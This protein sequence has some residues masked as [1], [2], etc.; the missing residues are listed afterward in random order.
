MWAHVS[1]FCVAKRGSAP[2]E[3]ED[4]AWISPTGDRVGDVNE[5]ALRVVVADGA[6]ESLLAGKWAKSLTA[7][8]GET[9]TAT[10]SKHEFFNAYRD[11]VERWDA[12][13]GLYITER[14][15][16]GAPIQWYEEPGL[17]RGAFSTIIALDVTRRGSGLGFWRAAAVGDSCVFHVS[18][19][20]LL[21]SFPLE[22]DEAFSNEP[23][24]LPSQPADEE[25]ISRNVSLCRSGW[26]R[27]DSLYVVTDAIAAWF[28]RANAAGDRPWEQL[29]DLAT[30]DAPDFSTWVAMRR[31]DGELRNDDTTLVRIDL[32]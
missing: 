19:E 8:F 25:T 5:R 31:D 2:T 26:E 17:A 12:E 28:L 23:P 4:A 16:R 18:D 3:C 11:A 30:A 20:A 24:L 22:D 32:Y 10:R 14:E 21:Y 27:G 29:R 13:L 9:A 15:Q 7:N 1:S 6:S